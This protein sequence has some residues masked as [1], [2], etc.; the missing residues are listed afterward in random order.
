MA[1]SSLP[2]FFRRDRD[3]RLT[4][5]RE[6]ASLDDGDI[7]VLSGA[8]GIAF[9]EADSMVENAVG[10]FGVPLGMATNFVVNSR[11]VIVPMATE[12]SSVIAAASRGAKA[13]RATGGF[14]ARAGDAHMIGQ[15]QVTGDYASDAEARVA[16]AA[17]AIL[18][19]ANSASRTLPRL[20]HGAKSVSCR[21]VKTDGPEQLVVEIDVDV[22][23][24]MGANATNSMCEAAAPVIETAT[25]GRALMRILSN[26]STR[27]TVS[28]TAVFEKSEVGGSGTVNDM[29]LA[30]QLAKHDM[31][32]AVTHN[33]GIMNGIVA[34]ASAVGQDVRAIEAAAHAHAARSGV[35][36]SLSEWSV[37]ENGNLV[38]RLEIPLAVGIIGGISGIHATARVC[39]KI[40]RV[41]SSGDLAC[42]MAAAGL[43]QNYSAMRALVTTGI[44]AG[45][46]RLH[47]RNLAIAAGARPD[48]AAAIAKQMV[49]EGDIS[50]GRAREILGTARSAEA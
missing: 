24:A 15:V 44:Q 17:D 34:V 37:D 29:I 4:A 38:G 23:D 9:G 21:R 22:G 49:K 5:L 50:E 46:M 20:G 33:K 6:A 32:R 47:A 19:A 45:H 12:E 39:A 11:D 8:G 43:A 36:S 28:V 27:R 7:A 35:Y 48:R 10:T 40:M 13:A 14:S 2:G 26:Y 30:H 3:E 42:I 16:D 18:D 31:Y 41:S 25:K 1:G